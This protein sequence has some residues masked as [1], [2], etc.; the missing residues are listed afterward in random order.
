MDPI[1]RTNE[2]R[3]GLRTCTSMKFE[4]VLAELGYTSIAFEIALVFWQ[5]LVTA[6]RTFN[7]CPRGRRPDATRIFVDIGLGFHAE[8]TWDETIGFCEKMEIDLNR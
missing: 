6:Y 3:R 5:M 4:T 2:Q 7:P 1:K 8:L